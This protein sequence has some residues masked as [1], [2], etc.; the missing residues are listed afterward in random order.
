MV[1]DFEG[2]QLKRWELTPHFYPFWVSGLVGIT[3]AIDYLTGPEIHFPILYLLPIGLVAWSGKQRWGYF[4]ALTMPLI[5]PCFSVIQ[6]TTWHIPDAVLNS[7]I[8]MMVF[9]LLVYLIGRAARQHQA[10]LEE[11]RILSGILPIC[12]FCKKIRNEK[13]EWTHLEQYISDHSEAEFSHGLCP[14]CLQQHYPDLN[15]S[16]TPQP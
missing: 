11:V 5:R 9:V 8:R 1:K 6:P 13:D 14:D 15:V 10:L 3:I 12:S 4:L 16:R 7:V 2:E